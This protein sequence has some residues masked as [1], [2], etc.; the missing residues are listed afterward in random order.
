MRKELTLGLDSGVDTDFP[1]KNVLNQKAGVVFKK[2]RATLAA[3]Q[4]GVAMPFQLNRS[5]FILICL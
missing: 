4:S 3:S 1:K 5:R 2:V